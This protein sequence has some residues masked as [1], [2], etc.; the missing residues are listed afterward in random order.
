M[1]YRHHKN[2]PVTGHDKNLPYM[3]RTD[4]SRFFRRHERVVMDHCSPAYLNGHTGTVVDLQSS[5]VVVKLDRPGELISRGSKFVD[6]NGCIRC[7]SVT[8]KDI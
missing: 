2:T 1:E 7:K 4:G 3:E 5:A 6:E 8:L